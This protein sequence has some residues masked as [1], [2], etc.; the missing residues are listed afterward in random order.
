MH[1]PHLLETLA[2]I[3]ADLN[4]RLVLEGKPIN[5]WHQLTALPKR[6]FVSVLIYRLRRYFHF[7]NNL[8][9][10]IIARLLKF[11]EFH[12]CH[13]EIDPRAEIGPG[14]VL[15]DLGGVG[16]GFNVIIGK[17]CTFMGKGTPTLGAMEDID[18]EKDRIRIG[19]YCVLGHNA[20]IINPVT[21]ADGVQIMPNAVLMTHVKSAG[22]VIAGFPAKAID[23][24]DM[25]TIKTWSPLLS[26]H[27]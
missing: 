6:G 21:V 9:A 24:V 20:K 23:V 5:F 8:F 15:S 11:P 22:T 2:D 7:K 3:Q 16:L 1:P 13:N 27:I 18:L 12:Y 19:D 10:T 4:R 17:N 25:D 14:L 26:R